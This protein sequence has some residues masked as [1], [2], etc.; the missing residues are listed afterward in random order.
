[1]KYVIRKVPER[2]TVY[3]ERLIPGA[4]IYNDVEHRGAVESFVEAIKMA[5]DDAVYVQ[6]DMLLCEN[7][8]ARAE[9]HI[10]SYPD[11]VIVFSNPANDKKY[12]HIVQEG[13]Y[14]PINAGYLLCTYI[15]RK[16]GKA[17]VE[18]YERKG[19]KT[20]ELYKRYFEMQLDDALFF[21]FLYSVGR[22]VFVT[23]PNLA[24][25]P[26]NKS[27]IDARRPPRICVNFDYSRAAK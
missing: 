9:K 7:F 25:H 11:T 19:Y 27:I 5:D 24:G 3:L 2:D 16:T 12:T 10:S 1:M 26:K 21:H 22:D 23:V 14:S 15:P 4:L 8:C 17:F 18:W 20:I 13:H 6:D